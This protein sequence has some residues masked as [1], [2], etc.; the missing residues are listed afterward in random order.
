ML[1]FCLLA[2]AARPPPPHSRTHLW[3]G[4]ISFSALNEQKGE[5][6]KKQGI[7]LNPAL[8]QAF[9]TQD[10]DRAGIMPEENPKNSGKGF[11]ASYD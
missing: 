1:K 10:R 5:K 4:S 9:L 3:G 8:K 2:S 11:G 6:G 7:V